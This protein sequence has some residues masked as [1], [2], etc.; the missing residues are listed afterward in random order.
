MYAN[1]DAWA[2]LEQNEREAEGRREWGW[3]EENML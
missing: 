1:M 2:H 3:G